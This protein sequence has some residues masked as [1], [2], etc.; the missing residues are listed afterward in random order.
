MMNAVGAGTEYLIQKPAGNSLSLGRHAGA[1]RN[2][3][4]KPAQCPFLKVITKLCI[5][6]AFVKEMALK[7]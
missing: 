4:H 2:L 3:K 1:S 6:T 5:L 7:I